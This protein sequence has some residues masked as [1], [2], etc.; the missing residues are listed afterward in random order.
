[1]K[2]LIACAVIVSIALPAFAASDNNRRDCQGKGPPDQKIAACI[3]VIEDS[4]ESAANRARAYNSRGVVYHGKN[5]LDRALA[6][7]GDAIKLDPQY[8]RPYYNRGLVYAARRDYDAAI[9]E[10][11]QAIK[12]RSIHRTKRVRSSSSS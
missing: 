9:S 8:A 5:D 12:H 7:H 6:D 2:H 1:M 4:S 10:Y 11:D 3:R